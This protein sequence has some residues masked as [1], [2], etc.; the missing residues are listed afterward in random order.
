ME[1]T[2]DLYVIS[3]THWDREWYESFQRYRFR[4]VR[5]IDDL[6]DNLEKTPDFKIFHLDG[7][8]VVLED[9]LEVRPENEA[10]LRKLI[11][12]GRI[13]IGP[14]YV[15]PDE[16]LISGESL[17]KNLQR[18]DEICRDYEAQ[19]MKSGY[20]T[21]IFGHNSQ[22]PQILNGFDIHSAVLYRGIGD[23]EKDCFNWESPDGSSV[24]AA[25]MDRERS[26][27]NFYFAV[28]WP[29]EDGEYDEADAAERMKA[30]LVHEKE[31]AVCNALLMMDGVDHIDI[32]PRIPEMIR[33][34]EEQ[35]AGVSFHHVRVEEYFD[36]VRRQNPALETIRGALYHV[37][38]AGVNN[39]VLKN[40]LSSMVHIKQD[41][42][43]CEQL[44]STV[45]EPLNAFT[46]MMGKKLKL[47]GRNDY[48]LS[49]R[50]H[51][52]DKGWKYLLR[53][54]P[55]DS[56]C[57]CSGSEVHRDNEYRYRQ[58]YEIGGL[59]AK[60][61]AGLIARNIAI[62]G[63]YDGSILLYNPSGTA[64]SGLTC[65]TLPIR[66]TAGQNL[67]FYD[68]N[69]KEVDVQILESHSDIRS[70]H[71]LRH[72]IAFEGVSQ[73]KAVFQAEIPAFGYTVLSYKGLPGH[74][75]DPVKK[76]Y[77][78]ESF[79]PPKRLVGSL[80]TG[81]NRLDNGV[82]DILVNADGTLD[83]TDKKTGRTYAG[84]LTFEDCGDVG[85]GWNY[86]K[87][88]FD[89]K[90]L[91][92]GCCTVSVLN[93]GPLAAEVE[94]R[95][96]MQLPTEA[97]PDMR[98]RGSV[99]AEQEFVTVVTVLRDDPTLYFNTRIDN[100]TE[101]HRLRVLFPTGL[102]CRTFV[103]KTPFDLAEWEVKAED[104]SSKIEPE[105][106]VHPSQG[107]TSLTNGSERCSVFAKGL[108]EVEVTDNAERA[109]ALTLFRAFPHIT[110]STE[111]GDGRMN[112][113]LSFSYAFS[114]GG[115]NGTEA[116]RRCDRFRAGLY[117]QPFDRN[118]E[119]DALPAEGA[120]LSL[121]ESDKLVSTV[122]SDGEAL[123]VRLY[124]V[125]GK[126]ETVSLTFPQ[127]I[128]KA[129]LVRLDNTPVSALETEG[130]TVQVPCGAHQIVSVR[131][132]MK[133]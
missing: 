3:H 70:M 86:R 27:S 88:L 17:V 72:L 66:N 47:F 2:T 37:A 81:R 113:S 120:F 13:V 14:W 110:A 121:S 1:Q 40:V 78:F 54:H 122:V 71:R 7:Q 104:Y 5:M 23:Y 69:G 77:A 117:V 124:D 56:I 15:M 97:A 12:D 46:D 92:G 44:Y 18:G 90:I 93:D 30:L 48:T 43:A 119:A 102:D 87:P 106:F 59:A 34:F 99:L 67:R 83:V 91:S 50:R 29:Y 126:S 107:F 105:T 79:H 127:E 39:Q 55:H 130:R 51:Y 60:D 53:N 63:E 82:L 24:L 129:E 118:P 10:R 76:S 57:G 123:T 32:E 74:Y 35:I 128:A 41:N 80:M 65:C 75:I 94:I 20:V 131:V 58:A 19:P 6:L 101:D 116:L 62:N 52:L 22:F 49:P 36:A 95:H 103:T 98:S 73:T 112:R 8:T 115:E 31:R 111:K 68:A 108:Y 61:A 89:R 4:L 109:V 26:Y 11:K 33:R 132:K 85:D 133:N 125:S 28:R 25:K 100:H 38:D 45:A 114:V 16:F 42:D 64:V 9:Y 84:L 96:K 21:D